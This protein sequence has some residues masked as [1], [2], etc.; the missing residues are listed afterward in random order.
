MLARLI[1]AKLE[2]QLARESGHWDT[3]VLKSAIAVLPER[4]YTPFTGKN[5][6]GQDSTGGPGA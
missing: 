5:S 6:L 2:S 4:P 3:S 1:T